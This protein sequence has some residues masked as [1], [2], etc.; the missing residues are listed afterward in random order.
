MFGHL[1]YLIFFLLTLGAFAIEVLALIDA[2]RR[3]QRAFSMEG[4]KTKKFWVVLLTIAAVIG[5]LGLEPPLGVG[6]LGLTAIFIAIPAFVYFADVFPAVKQYG[7]GKGNNGQ[8]N[9]GG[10]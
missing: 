2:A 9:R 5:F 6:Y 1:Q 8:N 7:Y 4:K 3:P 10:W